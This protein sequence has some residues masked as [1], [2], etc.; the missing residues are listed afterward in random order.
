MS[1]AGRSLGAKE[2]RLARA[3]PRDRLL[4]ETD[5]PDQLPAALRPR[6]LHNEPAAIRLSCV[7]LAQV[8][9][10]LCVWREGV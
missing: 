3:V 9:H 5:A 8:P 2:T 4:L 7:L 1:L 6:L 10:V